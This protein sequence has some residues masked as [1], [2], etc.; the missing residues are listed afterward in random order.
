[1]LDVDGQGGQPAMA[2]TW[3]LLHDRAP[4]G[5]RWGWKDFYDEDAPM[6]DPVQTMA[7]PPVPDLITY[8]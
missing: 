5:D 6:L 3:A 7:V 4:A 8:Q 2:G 1:M